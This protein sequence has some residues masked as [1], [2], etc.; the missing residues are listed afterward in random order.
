MMPADVESILRL[1]VPVIVQI[2]DRTMPLGEV[3]SLVPGAIIE[4]PK[5]A[6]HELEVLVNNQLIGRG[7]AVKVGENFGIR[8]SS[9]GSSRRRLEA[10]SRPGASTAAPSAPHP[11]I[12]AAT[13]GSAL[14]E[15]LLAGR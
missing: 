4:L 14:A 6:D 13:G 9:V 10:A 8:I 1:Q 5:P 11:S 2:G 7:K 15:Q 12:S 3:R